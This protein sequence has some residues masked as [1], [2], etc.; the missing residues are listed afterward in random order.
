MEGVTI[1]NACPSGS[2]VIVTV[3]SELGL[4]LNF[5]SNGPLELVNDARMLIQ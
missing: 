3:R 2:T 4:V 5:I 1:N